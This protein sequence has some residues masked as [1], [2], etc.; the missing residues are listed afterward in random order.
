MAMLPEIHNRV[1]AVS[2]KVPVSISQRSEARKTVQSEVGHVPS[3]FT[4][5]FLDHALRVF[6]LA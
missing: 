5:L 4:R 1:N 6:V 2:G 3:G